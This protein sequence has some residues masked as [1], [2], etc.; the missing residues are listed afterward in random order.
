MLAAH[1]CGQIY[2]AGVAVR[3]GTPAPVLVAVSGR[4]RAFQPKPARRRAPQELHLVAEPLTLRV[5]VTPARTRVVRALRAALTVGVGLT[6]ARTALDVRLPVQAWS[7]LV[8]TSLEH[9]L[10]VAAVGLRARLR[11]GTEAQAVSVELA[12]EAWHGA[13]GHAA[14]LEVGL[15]ALPARITLAHRMRSEGAEIE[16]TVGGAGGRLGWTGGPGLTAV[17][18][19]V[20]SA[21]LAVELADP[22]RGAALAILEEDEMHA[23]HG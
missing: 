17:S 15:D 13:A 21:E 5:V 12:G 4:A 8:A 18:I 23:T 10:T 2:P 3:G 11:L 19:E 7:T 22:L 16:V 1:Y 9:A 6:T 20:A 14:R